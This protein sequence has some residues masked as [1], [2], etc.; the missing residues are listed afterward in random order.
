MAANM[1][2]K[3]VK[4]VRKALEGWPVREVHAWSYSSVVLSWIR[5]QNRFKQSN[6]MAELN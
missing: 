2:I 3:L 5:G 1:A 6:H 4:N